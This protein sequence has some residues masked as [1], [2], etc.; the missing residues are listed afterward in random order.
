MH[1]I[2]QYVLSALVTKTLAASSNVTNSS[3]ISAGFNGE[4][5]RTTDSS[6]CERSPFVYW[7]R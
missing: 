4:M 3:G 2:T 7:L 1:F 5:V 6:F